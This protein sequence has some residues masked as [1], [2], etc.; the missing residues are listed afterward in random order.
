MIIIIIICQQHAWIL[1][2]TCLIIW[3]PK[4]LLTYFKMYMFSLL[5]K[6]K[7]QKWNLCQQILCLLSSSWVQLVLYFK[8]IKMSGLITFFYFRYI[9]MYLFTVSSVTVLFIFYVIHHFTCLSAYANVIF[10][11]SQANFDSCRT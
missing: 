11:F 8:L 9:L 2:F 7:K 5:S 4:S 6:D 3:R 1:S 10:T